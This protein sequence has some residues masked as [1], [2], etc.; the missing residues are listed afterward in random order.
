MTNIIIKTLLTL[1]YILSP[2]TLL[3]LHEIIADVYNSTSFANNIH[4]AG[5]H[6]DW[7]QTSVYRTAQNFI[8]QK[9]NHT[10]NNINI[11]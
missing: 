3:R 9:V 4:Y 2:I 11:T 8:Q 10:A 1:L 5:F 7:F 6:Q